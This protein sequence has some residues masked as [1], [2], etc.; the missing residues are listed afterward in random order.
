M[1]VGRFFDTASP[2]LLLVLGALAATAPLAVDMYLPALPAI[3]EELQAPISRVQQ[4]LAVF[5]LGFAACQV[6][7]GPLS[8][9]FGRKPVILFGL[10][11]FAVASLLCARAGSVSELLTWRLL[12][13]LGGGA[14][15]VVV[16]ALV[17]DLYQGDEAARAMSLVIMSMTLAPL[18]APLLGGQV[19]LWFDWRLIFYLL[20]GFALLLAL[21]IWRRL[22]E[23]L[24]QPRTLSPGNLARGYLAVLVHRSALG[25]LLCAAFSF[26]GMFAFIAGSPFVYIGYFGVSEQFYGLL[27]GANVL[28]MM[29]LNWMNRRWVMTLGGARLIRVATWVQLLCGL[30]MV[31]LVVMDAATLV[32]LVPLL[33]AFVGMIGL[34]GANT[35]AGVLTPFGHSAGSASALLGS[36]RFLTGAGAAA[37]VG[38][39]HDET[40]LPMVAVIAG[41]GLLSFASYRLLVP[42][43]SERGEEQPQG[44]QQENRAG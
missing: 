27:F 41:C 33:V 39:F 14:T 42:P 1:P 22:P 25:H 10:L 30:G 38:W 34:L 37:L 3:A 13:A 40:P 44:E 31:A 8:D 15:S 17:R 18:L 26:A 12:Q 19:L 29:L 20:A 23:T 35:T 21:L 16:A 36:L 28:V 11:L 9:R 32:L 2:A 24:S 43:R 5:M 4:T 6:L 7:Y